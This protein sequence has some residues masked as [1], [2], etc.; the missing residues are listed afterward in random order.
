MQKLLF[1]RTLRDLK[2]NGFRYLAL[3]LL[4]AL[5]MFLV[6]STVGSA[7]S[8]IGTV[9]KKAEANCLEDGQFGTFI[10]LKETAMREI[11]AFGVTLEESFYLDFPMKDGST[12]RIM[13]NRET[14][15]LIEPDKGRTAKHSG[16]LLVERI[17]AEAHGLTPGDMITVAGTDFSICGT[18]TTPDY[19]YCLRNMTDMSSDGRIFGTA[20]VTPEAYDALRDTGSALHSEE[21]RYSYRLSESAD[22]GATD[23]ADLLKEYL[24]NTAI[25]PEEVNDVYFQEMV[26]LKTEDR[27]SLTD[28]IQTLADG[29]AALSAAL[30]GFSR[31]NSGF[32]QSAVLSDAG[33]E[34]ASLLAAQAK[35]LQRGMEAFQKNTDVM[36]NEYFP[37]EAENL[38]DFV[39]AEDNP[40]IKA[41][42]GDVELNINVGLM[43]GFIVLVL[44]T[45]VIS[46]FVIH[47]IDLESTMIGA[48]YALGLKR[49]QL[50]L[51]YT[52]LP[53]L[54]CL[55]GGAAGTLAGYS[56]PGISLM[57]G[58]SRS[59]FSTPAIETVYSP[60]LLIYGFVL[61]PLTAFIINRIII[62]KR[63]SRSALSLLRRE[64]PRR[65]TSRF[66][67]T[68]SGI[69][70]RLQSS[71][72]SCQ[73]TGNPAR[74]KSGT[75]PDWQSV[76]RSGPRAGFLRTF[77]I[78]QFLRERRSCL[79]V[80][81][82]MFV[83]LL[84]LMLGLNCYALCLNVRAE[85]KSDTRYSYL[86]QYKYPISEV[87]EGGFA[88]YME[89]LKQ[90]VLGYDMEVTLIGLSEENPF[91]P[92]ITSKRKNELS[93]SSSVAQKYGLSAGD[94]FILRD[95]VNER[96][97]GF[98]VKEVVPYSAGLCCF[99]DIGSMRSLFDREADYYNAVYSDRELDVE[100]GR[101]YAVS[102]KED[103][104][105]SS[106]IFMQIM[107]PLI[108]IMTAASAFI[109]LVVLYQMMKVM[110]D[111][112]SA[113]ISLMKIFGY[114]NGE[115]RKLYL[116][117]SFLLIVLGALIMLPA[118]KLLMDAVYPC[119]IANVACGL[120]LSWPPALYLA[121]Y[122]G[123]LLFYLIIRTVLMRRLKKLSPAAVLKDTE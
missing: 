21:Y 49:K 57:T 16:E 8:V 99:M 121:V 32:L 12:L 114:R 93:I 68:P 120:N 22:G 15:N 65:K 53:V 62:R 69:Q 86:Y 26:S 23:F 72:L 80:L 18:G 47:S 71:A 4:I 88:A 102:T 59:Y 63:L 74:R 98:T 13:K 5:S 94:E 100:A 70:S 77:Q 51:H 45:Y 92:E 30:E 76:F 44:I 115:I 34:T 116:D 66:R 111:R 9:D 107:I 96:I 101:L 39:K 33:Q 119:F 27:T 73:L 108:V 2:A 28:G 104:E 52:M 42:S 31:M 105:K 46:V 113:S 50:E 7:E 112:S 106:D 87:P 48:L 85:T 35:E 79:A 19:D 41:A 82:G 25:R 109:F 89:G 95:D 90:E 117:G 58:Q 20:F 91:F 123:I 36:L 60:W 3:F 61:P 54:L 81:G 10:P 103:A 84:V 78:R 1:K 37:L 64:A 40:R 110:I 11:R 17:Y 6:V 67:Q 122:A 97:Y 56:K 75:R 118:A 43:A 24:L 38:T 14:V 55:L 83:S 29:T